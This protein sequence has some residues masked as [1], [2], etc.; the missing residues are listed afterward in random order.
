MRLNE[1]TVLNFHSAYFFA[2]SCVALLE[3]YELLLEWFKVCFLG[4]VLIQEEVSFGRCKP[5]LILKLNYI[6]Q[7]Q[8]LSLNTCC[9]II[10]DFRQLST[11]TIFAGRARHFNHKFAR[12]VLIPCNG[13]SCASKW[14]FRQSSAWFIEIWW[15]RWLIWETLRHVSVVE[16][17]R[18]GAWL[19]QVR[20]W[21]PRWFWNVREKR[22]RRSLVSVGRAQRH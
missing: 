22:S 1:R 9:L 17:D 21:W 14:T 10:A 19:A 6:C 4:W 11:S 15:S 7:G 18:K 3:W 13:L 5:R 12:S 8:V 2:H 20:I 16:T